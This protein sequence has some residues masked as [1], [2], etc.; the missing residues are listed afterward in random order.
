MSQPSANRIIKRVSEAIAP[1]LR[2]NYITFPEGDILDQLKLDFWRIQAVCGP[3]L[4]IL[5]I[6]ARWP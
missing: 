2:N 4:D 3:N 1:R 6:V 5:N